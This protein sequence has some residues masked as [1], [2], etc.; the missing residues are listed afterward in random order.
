M[1]NKTVARL[2]S[3]AQR[4][5]GWARTALEHFAEIGLQEYIKGEMR[6]G[7]TSLMRNPMTGKAAK[8]SSYIGVRARTE[9]G[10]PA[11]H[12]QQEL[13]WTPPWPV[14]AEKID[15]YV[16]HRNT[17]DTNVAMFGEVMKLRDKYPDSRTPEEACEM[18]G[19]DPRAFGIEGDVFM[20]TN[21]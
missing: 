15:N 16:K 18:A 6:G 3:A 12:Y 21:G 7:D 8:V 9:D 11:G 14:F 19:I 17:V 1:A 20:G 4:G 10:L 13:W 5:A 2:S